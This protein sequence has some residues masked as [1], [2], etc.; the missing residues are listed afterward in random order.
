LLGYDGAGI[1]LSLGDRGDQKEEQYEDSRW[2]AVSLAE[3]ATGT[4]VRRWRRHGSR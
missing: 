2:H 4:D 1:I 3:G